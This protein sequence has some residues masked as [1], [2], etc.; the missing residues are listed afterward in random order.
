MRLTVI[1]GGGSVGARVLDDVAHD[2]APVGHRQQL[3]CIL[4]NM[5][6]GEAGQEWT[7]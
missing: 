4:A 1:E 3:I 6:H 2:R 7:V 5:A